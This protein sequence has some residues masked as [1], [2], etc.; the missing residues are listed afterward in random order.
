MKR[1]LL[2]LAAAI[3][4]CV[5]ALPS[6]VSA[7]SGQNYANYALGSTVLVYDISQK[8]LVSGFIV[9]A[10]DSRIYVVTDVAILSSDQDTLDVIVVYG[11]LYNSEGNPDGYAY[12]DANVE[13]IDLETG[14]V[15]LSTRAVREATSSHVPSVLANSG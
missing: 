7:D 12:A 10:T 2:A 6:G 3:I 8:S 4:L 13:Y 11:T 9:S 14:I 1:K 5:T 15:I